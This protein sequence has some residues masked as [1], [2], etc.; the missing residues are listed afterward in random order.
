MKSDIALILDDDHDDGGDGDDDGG[1][2][3]DAKPVKPDLVSL[4]MV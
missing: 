2:G 3:R 1:R 4:D